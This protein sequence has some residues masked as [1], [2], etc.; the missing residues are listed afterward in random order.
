MKMAPIKPPVT[1]LYIS[2]EETGFYEGFSKSV[3][4]GSK[5]LIGALILWAIAFPSAAGRFL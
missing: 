5:L 3:A 4:I 1:D 2:T